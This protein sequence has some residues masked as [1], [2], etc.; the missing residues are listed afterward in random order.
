MNIIRSSCY[1]EFPDIIY[2]SQKEILK[3][4]VVR[5]MRCTGSYTNNIHDEINSS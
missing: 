3:A 4:K 5:E 2:L 1:H